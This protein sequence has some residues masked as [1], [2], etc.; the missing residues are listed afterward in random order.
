[1]PRPR[2]PLHGRSPT[3]Q[4]ALPPDRGRRRRRCALDRRAALG[5]EHLIVDPPCA[6]ARAQ[7]RHVLQRGFQPAGGVRVE[8]LA[9]GAG[10]A[11]EDRHFRLGRLWLAV[12]LAATAL[13]PPPLSSVTSDTPHVRL[14]APSF[15]AL[16]AGRGP[17]LRARSSRFPARCSRTPPGHSRERRSRPRAAPRLSR[18]RA[19]DPCRA[20]C[21]SKSP[22]T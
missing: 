7:Q 18:R 9:P 5:G 13:R 2:G 14:T 8:G 22:T 21:S 17:G 12:S 20:G 15:K 19:A 16:C 6:L 3:C 11:H 1:M 10:H 4:E